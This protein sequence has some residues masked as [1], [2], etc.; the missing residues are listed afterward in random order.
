MSRLALLTLLMAVVVEACGS[1]GPDPGSAGLPTPQEPVPSPNP[2]TVAAPVKGLSDNPAYQWWRRPNGAQPDSWWGD[3]QDQS[4]LE[5]QTTLMT[6]LGVKLL[7]VELPWIFVAPDMP[8]ATAYDGTVARDPDWAG[9]HWQRWDLIVSVAARAGIELVPEVVYAPGWATGVAPTLNGGPSRPPLSAEYYPDFIHALVA[10]Y[11]GEIHY[12]ELGNEPDVSPNTWTG[13]LQSYVDLMLKPGYEAVKSVD[14]RAQVVMGGLALSNRMSAMYAAGAGPYFDI[15]NFHAYY[16]APSADSTALDFVR[17]AMHAN[18]DDGKPIWMTEFG[19]PSHIPT[20]GAGPL[21]PISQPDEE[22]QAALVRGVYAHMKIEAIFFYQ[23]R[24][25]A[26]YDSSDHMIKL[27]Y[28]GLV[29]RD[30]TR[31]KV[32]YDAYRDAVGGQLPPRGGGRTTTQAA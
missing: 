10:R 23:L 28:W 19:L 9:Y 14:P 29:N 24:D 18:G 26:V 12:W 32:S 13:T 4:S 3:Q 15:A 16:T 21:D 7:R 31:R 27:V 6:D 2:V 22:K 30:L 17:Q 25:T 20:G 1:A 5:A 8:G 11:R